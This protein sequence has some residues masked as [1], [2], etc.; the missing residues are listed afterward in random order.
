VHQLVSKI[1]WF[2]VR[3]HIR[4]LKLPKTS[5]PSSQ[6]SVSTCRTIRRHTR[7]CH[8]RENPNIDSC[9]SDCL[10]SHGG[11]HY[12][13]HDIIQTGPILFTWC[14]RI[15]TVQYFQEAVI[16]LFLSKALPWLKRSVAGLYPR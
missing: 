4:P 11:H 8:R 1:L 7:N 9:C 3:Y 10:Q 14:G 2:K 6:T 5:A 16:L 15:C 13:S 12:V